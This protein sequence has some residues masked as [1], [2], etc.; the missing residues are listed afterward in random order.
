MHGICCHTSVFL[1]RPTPTHN[2]TL[3]VILKISI[4]QFANPTT[5]IV[6]KYMFGGAMLDLFKVKYIFC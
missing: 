3:Q 4:F 6:I 2:N 1:I 5:S